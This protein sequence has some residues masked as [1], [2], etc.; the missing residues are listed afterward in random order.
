M[1]IQRLKL[2]DFRSYAHLDLD[3][4]GRVTVIRGQNAQ[5]KSTIEQAI[6]YAL[7]A[8]A[9]GTTAAG[10]GADETLIRNGSEIARVFLDLLVDGKVDKLRVTLSRKSGRALV[11]KDPEGVE[12]THT[13]NPWLR[14]HAEV[15]SCLTNSR[16]FV[17]LDP[18]KQKDILSAI[19]LP[20]TYDGWDPEIIAAARKVAIP[21]DGWNTAHPFQVIGTAYDD[22]F[23]MRKNVNRDLKNFV[24]PS[25]DISDAGDVAEIKAKLKERRDQ[26]AG[27]QGK[28]AKLLAGVVSPDVIAERKRKTLER[29]AKA[30]A[31]LAT[32]TRSLT[33]HQA[34][35]LDKKSLKANQAL[36]A[37][38]KHAASLDEQISGL[39]YE[40]NS[41]QA[42]IEKAETLDDRCPSCLQAVTDDIRRIIIQPL[43]DRQE[44]AK[45]SLRAR[46]QDRAAIGDFSLALQSLAD[47]LA[48]EKEVIRTTERLEEA[49][50]E[51]VGAN[52]D[53]EAIGESSAPV[54]TALIDAEIA[55]LTAR[56]DRGTHRLSVV[57]AANERKQ[58]FDAA[59][60]K[61]QAL[62]EKAALLEKLVAYFGPAGVQATLLE[63]YVG[64]F[65]ASMNEVLKAWGYQCALGFEPQ[66]FFGLVTPVAD[67][68]RM[69]PLRTLSKSE[70][71]RFA[72]AFQVAL[73][74]HTGFRFVVVD[75]TD[76]LDSEG[77]AGL[78]QQI[79]AS[80][81]DQ[82]ILLGTDQRAT[83]S[84][85]MAQAAD[86]FMVS[87]SLVD[88]IP[89]SSVARLQPAV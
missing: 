13:L 85:G 18:A 21:V 69:W 32:E 12:T 3:L 47:H 83:I 15:L 46:K 68:A 87:S 75:E 51:R 26:L 71:Y 78:M 70:R 80:N 34:K 81:L 42:A 31:K 14:G 29:L 59:Q 84:P 4:S 53:L 2:E 89:T 7:A 41:L 52:A 76:M 30:E 77:R 60:K 86:F 8:R 11:A 73:A 79:L 82:A 88:G 10:A 36:A 55:D 35:I 37:Q 16:H 39:T 27:A 67:G 28:R 40:V 43:F 48:A 74:M 38:E 25:G 17:D 9:E 49:K 24:A 20:A 72:I 63:Q 5:G 66:F 61:M 58:A 56:I 50:A 6:Q 65:T 62:K 33:E 54:D 23:E 64:A 19:V 44:T 1:K 45:A 57:S 22:A